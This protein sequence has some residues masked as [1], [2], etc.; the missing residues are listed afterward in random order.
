MWMVGLKPVLDIRVP[1]LIGKSVGEQL[2]RLK[3][4]LIQVPS[5]QILPKTKPMCLMFVVHV[6]PMVFV[7][8]ILVL[9]REV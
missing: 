2:D 7:K 3:T 4:H 6:T 9:D 8:T 1:D 5:V